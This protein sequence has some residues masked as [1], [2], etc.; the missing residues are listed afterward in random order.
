[1]ENPDLIF[2]KITKVID[3]QNF[4]IEILT[5]LE[6][7]KII[8][9][10]KERIKLLCSIGYL[11]NHEIGKLLGE[12]IELLIVSRNSEGNLECISGDIVEKA[13]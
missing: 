3:Y 8:Y 11:I 6:S 12:T 9:H 7:N 1:M 13:I 5:Q 4:D 2:G 10:S